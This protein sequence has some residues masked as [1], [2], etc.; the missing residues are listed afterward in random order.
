MGRILRAQCNVWWLG[1]MWAVAIFWLAESLAA[2]EW[3]DSSGQFKVEAEL[4]GVLG[5]KVKLRKTDGSVIEIPRSKLS[6]A[7][8]EFLAKRARQRRSTSPLTTTPPP[9]TPTPEPTATAPQTAAPLGRAAALKSGRVAIEQALAKRGNL[10]FTDEPLSRAV[11]QLG[12]AAGVPAVTDSIAFDEEGIDAAVPVTYSGNAT[13]R[14]SLEAMLAPLN[15]AWTVKHDVLYVTTRR[16]VDEIFELRTYVYI[17]PIN[18]AD[19]YVV[20]DELVVDVQARVLPSTWDV[21]GGPANIDTLPPCVVVLQTPANHR[22]LEAAYAGVLALV[23]PPTQP[24]PTVLSTKWPALLR[25]LS[26]P[27]TAQWENVPLGDALKQLA[28]QCKIKITQN[29]PE[30]AELGIQRDTPVSLNVSN[31]PLNSL[32]RLLLE[33]LELSHLP[34][35]QGLEITTL[36][37]AGQPEALLEVEYPVAPL[38]QALCDGDLDRFKQATTSTVSPISWQQVGGR[39]SIEFNAQG[40]VIRHTLENHLQIDRLYSELASVLRP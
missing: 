32:L 4:V 26:T 38:V 5:D 36:E 28:D 8:Q 18:P 30:L 17:K 16:A 1:L 3:S 22:E 11:H 10:N 6:V 33:P 25:A 14:E 31:V 34:T 23:P 27:A 13:F 12:I 24:V 15:L 21:V 29:E 9:A 35:A 19:K 2:R 39:A 7:D 40:V 37:A 20:F